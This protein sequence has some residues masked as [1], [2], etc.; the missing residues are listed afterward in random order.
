V[1]SP[2]QPAKACSGEYVVGDENRGA[3]KEAKTENRQQES[4]SEHELFL[5]TPVAAEVLRVVPSADR[6]RE[7]FAELAR[8]AE[9]A[10][11]QLCAVLNGRLRNATAGGG[12]LH[13][14]EGG[15]KQQS[16]QSQRCE[17]RHQG[18]D[19]QSNES[20]HRVHVPF[21]LA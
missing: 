9:G 19:D 16:L 15:A 3:C 8:P 5:S 11:D 12:G 17:E 2:Q 6:E 10:S 14:R 4:Q 13:E 20:K 21:P 7:T 1:I 18:G